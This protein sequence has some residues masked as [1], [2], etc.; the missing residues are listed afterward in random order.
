M[1]L[2]FRLPWQRQEFY[3]EGEGRP[4]RK[5]ETLKQTAEKIIQRKMKRDADG[6]G[7]RAAEKLTGIEKEE[8]KSLAEQIKTLKEVKNFLKDLGGGEGKSTFGEI[9][10]ILPEVMPSVIQLV[11]GLRGQALPPGQPGQ[12]TLEEGEY[13]PPVPQ[14]EQPK[15]IKPIKPIKPPKP[16]KVIKPPPVKPPQAQLS[17]LLPYLEDTPENAVE[18][19]KEQVVVNNYQAIVWF[20]LMRTKSY[21]EL[22]SLLQPFKEN[23]TYGEAVNKLLAKGK[24]KWFKTFIELVKSVEI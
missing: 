19:L 1:R 9:I 17:E 22:V 5:K 24:G 12:P 13:V 11:L 6:Y 4:L 18:A 10:S 7:L 16:P 2:R 23:E 8:G 21:E 14:I 3:L 20:S 15:P